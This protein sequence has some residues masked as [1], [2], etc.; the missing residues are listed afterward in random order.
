VTGRQERKLRRL[1]EDLKG[2]Q[3]ILTSKGY[4]GHLGVA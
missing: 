1:L 4:F 3:R 2:K